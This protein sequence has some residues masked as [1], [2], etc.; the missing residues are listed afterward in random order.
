MSQTTQNDLPQKAELTFV[1]CGKVL[2]QGKLQTKDCL[3][4][5]R[6]FFPASKII[7]STWLGEPTEELA[8]MTRSYSPTGPSADPNTALC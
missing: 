3:A 1:V 2:T 7:L 4:S 6:E 8:F 5:I